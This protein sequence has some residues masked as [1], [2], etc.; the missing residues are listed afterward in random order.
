MWQYIV[1]RLVGSVI[2]LF[3]VSVFVFTTI[4]ALPGDALLVKLGEAR[5]LTAEQEAA[6]RHE[7]GLDDPLFVAYGKWV[8]GFLRGDAGDSLILENTSV[9]SRIQRALAPTLELAILSALVGLP[10]AIGLGAVSALRQ[11]TWLDYPLRMVA[12]AGISI[13]SFVLAT[14]ILVFMARTWNYA[15]PFGW[16]NFWEDP[17]KNLEQVYIPVLILGFGF[18]ATTMRIT[19][20]AVLEVMRQDFVRTARAKGLHAR[21]V[22]THHIMR[23]ALVSVTTLVGLQ[24]VFLI[25]GSLILEI[26]FAIPG[27]G[28]LTLTAI[29]QRDYPQ[30]MANTMFFATLL[31]MSNLAVDLLYSVLDPRVKYS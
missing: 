23:N 7:L 13:P 14:A 18:S 15:P 22:F 28:R 6:A 30:I 12:V 3:L 17:L 11:D 20:S 5:N 4:R 10:F 31:V 8:S 26:I 9:S 19:R 16:V 2:V 1:R 25:S 24:V 29:Q 27:V 21:A